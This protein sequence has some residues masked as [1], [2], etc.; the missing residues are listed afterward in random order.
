MRKVIVPLG[1][2]FFYLQTLSKIIEAGIMLYFI[3]DGLYEVK[4]KNSLIASDFQLPA[5]D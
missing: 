4:H 1:Q 2:E 5:S 3:Y